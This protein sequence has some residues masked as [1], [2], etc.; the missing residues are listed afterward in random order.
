MLNYEYKTKERLNS[1]T[2]CGSVYNYVI[3]YFNTFKN[4]IKI[5]L[6]YIVIISLLISSISCSN[7]SQTIKKETANHLS[8]SIKL[9]LYDVELGDSL[10]VLLRNFPNIKQ[11]SL[12]SI[13]NYLPYIDEEGYAFKELGFSVY[14]VDT[15]FVADHKDYEHRRNGSQ[16]T[17]P[18]EKVKHHAILCFIV[19]DNKIIQ[20]EIYILSPIIGYDNI[21]LP[22]NDFRGAI[23][24]MFYDKYQIPDSILMLNRKTNEAAFVD[25]EDE[26]MQKT[27]FEQLGGTYVNNTVYKQDVWIWTNAKIY[28]DW[29]FSPYKNGRIWFWVYCGVVRVSYIDYYAIKKAQEEIQNE[30]LKA[31]EDSIR[32]IMEKQLEDTQLYNTQ[33]F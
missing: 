25:Y 1:I 11:I 24:K 6:S 15:V 17:F 20:S 7:S 4:K 14:K 3:K 23:R 16:I 29:D 26:I 27:I 31:K 21:D 2:G 30:I 13:S 32:I 9:S 12:D 10:N 28:A 33:D 18:L 8:D 5:V 19:K 22:S